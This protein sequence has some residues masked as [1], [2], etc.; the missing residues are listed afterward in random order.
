MSLTRQVV[1][2]E[3]GKAGADP[4]G[5]AGCAEAFPPHLHEQAMPTQGFERGSLRCGWLADF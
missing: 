5:T 1:T 3:D 2:D 4:T